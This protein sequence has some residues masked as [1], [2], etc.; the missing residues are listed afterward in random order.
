MRFQRYILNEEV[1]QSNEIAD[2]LKKDCKPYFKEV[3]LDAP[4]LWRGQHSVTIP[5]I[6]KIVPRKDRRPRNTPIN[7]HKIWDNAFKKK[8]GWKARS[9][10]VFVGDEF[11]AV[12]YGRVYMFFPIGSYKYVWSEKYEDLTNNFDSETFRYFTRLS[13][14][15]IEGYLEDKFRNQQLNYNFDSDAFIKWKRENVEKIHKE[16]MKK[17]E[18][19]VNDYTDKNLKSSL[20]NKSEVSFLC[21]SYYLV[22]RM[23][24][25]ELKKIL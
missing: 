10:G 21:K 11:D 20:K 19:V 23:Y 24:E 2:I 4:F 18:G 15:S 9:E 14:D 3:G 22:N 13:K 25:E 17:A 12:Y 16:M 7:L 8:F 5:D 1:Y 6:E